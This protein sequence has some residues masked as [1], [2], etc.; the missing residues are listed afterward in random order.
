MPESHSEYWARRA[1]EHERL[2]QAAGHRAAMAAH[3]ALAQA[4]RQR[5]ERGDVEVV[6]WGQQRAARGR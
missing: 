2:A 1:C 4:Y 5:A 6:D 3:H